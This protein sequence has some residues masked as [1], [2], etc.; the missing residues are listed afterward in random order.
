M[1]S[2]A[3]S[4]MISFGRVAMTVASTTMSTSWNWVSVR[5]GSSSSACTSSTVTWRATFV[6]AVMTRCTV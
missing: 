5:L 6:G 4:A 2:Q 3:S 1:K